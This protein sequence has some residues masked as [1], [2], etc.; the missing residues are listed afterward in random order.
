MTSGV[1]CITN[2][3]TGDRYVGKSANIE[4]RLRS[5]KSGMKRGDSRPPHSKLLVESC[6]QYGIDTFAFEILE[7]CSADELADKEWYWNNRL[8]PSFN[9]LQ[10]VVM[11]NGEKIWRMDEAIVDA[12]NA[13]TI[14]WWKSQSSEQRSERAK[15]TWLKRKQPISSQHISS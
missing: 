1:Y 4:A 14:S 15:A 11:F 5:H 10:A 7:E 13:A 2:T 3:V 8:K 6:H 9:P 12:R